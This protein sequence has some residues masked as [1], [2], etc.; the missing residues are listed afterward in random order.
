MLSLKMQR[1]C[2][3][4]LL[5]C[6]KFKTYFVYSL[7]RGA[8]SLCAC[9]CVHMHVYNHCLFFQTLLQ[10][11]IGLSFYFSYG[12][13]LNKSASVNFLF[14]PHTAQG[15]GRLSQL[16]SNQRQDATWIRLYC[17]TGPY[18]ERGQGIMHIPLMWFWTVRRSQIYPEK[19]T[20]LLNL[21]REPHCSEANRLTTPPLH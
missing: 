8:V 21:N 14:G 7:F 6:H 12:G 13:R 5:C 15:A 19:Q 2:L 17:I 16:S 1:D 18:R 4:L 20:L 11:K 9:V 10:D 3:L